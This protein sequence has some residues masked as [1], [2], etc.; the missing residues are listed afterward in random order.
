MKSGAKIGKVLYFTTA[1][2]K[3]ITPAAEGCHRPA[4]KGTVP[5]HKPWPK[6]ATPIYNNRNHGKFVIFGPTNTVCHERDT[7]AR[8]LRVTPAPC[9]RR[10]G[11]LHGHRHAA[12]TPR[13]LASVR[14]RDAPRGTDPR[15]GRRHAG[16]PGQP[17]VHAASQGCLRGAYRVQ[18]GG[19]SHPHRRDR[20]LASLRIPGTGTHD[21]SRRSALPHGLR[22]NGHGE[23]RNQMRRRQP[24][25]QPDPATPRLSARPHRSTR[26]AARRRGI[27]R[28]QRI[29]AAAP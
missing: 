16:R 2:P 25:E 6:A 10:P 5:H 19:Q 12:R 1:Y 24:A 27:H 21:R 11:H 13:A 8:R 18:I 20:L 9:G 14:G 26:R 15:S 22:A 23:C 3:N 17:G 28:P 29:P 4:R 7:P